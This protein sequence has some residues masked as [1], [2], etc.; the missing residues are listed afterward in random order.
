MKTPARP[1]AICLLSV[2]LAGS[3]G[4]DAQSSGRPSTPAPLVTSS[5]EVVHTFPHDPAAFTQGLVFL[6]GD[7]LDGE[8]GY[9]GQ[10]G[11]FIVEPGG[12]RRYP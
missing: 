5:Y 1:L 9:A 10:I 2:C 4:C 3:A 8:S 7:L 6:D 11:H 12:R